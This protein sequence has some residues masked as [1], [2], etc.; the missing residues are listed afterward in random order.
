MPRHTVRVRRAASVVASSDLESSDSLH[1]GL[2]HP[3]HAQVRR[4]GL[5]ESTIILHVGMMVIIL[6]LYVGFLFS[7]HDLNAADQNVFD[8][9]QHRFTLV[10]VM[11]LFLIAL[12]IG[13]G[14][15]DT[16]TLT[17]GSFLVSVV[18]LGIIQEISTEVVYAMASGVA[19]I[20]FALTR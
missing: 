7:N 11:G 5:Q 6:I 18:S 12:L 19:A 10:P 20:V 2:H 8:F 1:H 4:I 16:N 15:T 9:T 17:L 3:L 13:K 14:L